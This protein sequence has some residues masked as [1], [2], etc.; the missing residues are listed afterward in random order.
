MKK[1]QYNIML[2]REITGSVGFLN[3]VRFHEAVGLLTVSFSDK[4]GKDT[5]PRKDW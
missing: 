3:S 4:R 2:Y 1:T 5:V